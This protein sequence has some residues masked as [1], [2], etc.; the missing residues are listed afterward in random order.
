MRWFRFGVVGAILTMSTGCGGD[1]D[2]TT[3]PTGQVTMPPEME[4]MKNEMDKRL[5]PLRNR[6]SHNKTQTH[7]PSAGSKS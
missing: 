5:L 7:R 4:K 6:Y 3:M 2:G 1:S